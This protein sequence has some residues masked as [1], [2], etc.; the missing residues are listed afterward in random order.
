MSVHADD[1]FSWLARSSDPAPSHNAA[2]K[3]DLPRSE[4]LV[5]QAI[6]DIGPATD[7]QVYQ[8]L[9][10]QGTPVSPS[11]GR[12]ARKALVRKQKVQ[13][14]PVKGVTQWGHEADRWDVVL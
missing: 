11:R 9:V 8:Y 5:L 4:Q 1:L 14:H 12:T 10:E 2:A 13:A 7:E 3:A 6:R